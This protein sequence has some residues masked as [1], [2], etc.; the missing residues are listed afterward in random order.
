MLEVEFHYKTRGGTQHITYTL[1]KDGMSNPLLEG[2]P[3]TSIIGG[4][5]GKLQWGWSSFP[6]AHYPNNLKLSLGKYQIELYI[7]GKQVDSTTFYVDKPI[8]AYAD[9]QQK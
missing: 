5:E 3:F 6:I 2:V 9:V 1:R 4:T 7:N 8:V